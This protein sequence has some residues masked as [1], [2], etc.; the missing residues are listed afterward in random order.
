M[1]KNK[2]VAFLLVAAIACCAFSAIACNNEKVTVPPAVA[3]KD[4][5]VSSLK[6]APDS[7]D[8]ETVIYAVV[9]KIKSYSTYTTRSTGSSVAKKGFITY[10]QNTECT[11]VKNGDE[12]YTD[13][14]SN[15][16]LVNT[17]HEV[18]VKNGKAA[19][20]NNSGTI[21]TATYDD[22]LDIYGVTPDKTISG[23]VFNHD[24][25]RYA[26]LEK[27]EGDTYT[28]KIVLDKDLAHA[29]I[30]KQMKMV[31]GLD[32]YPVFTKDTEAT[33][34]IKKDFTPVS[35]SYHSSYNI[36]IA[37]LGDV[38][39]T[40]EN[41]VYFENINKEVTLPDANAFN[42]A[43][44]EQPT[45]VDPGKTESKDENLDA[46]VSALLQADLE[47]GI[48]L[49]GTISVGEFS[50][51]VKIEGKADINGLMNGTADLYTA[52]QATASIVSPAGNAEVT[53]YNGKFYLN[54]LGGKYVFSTNI[55]A[56]NRIGIT[57][58]DVSQFIKITKSEDDESTYVVTLADAYNGLITTAL[59]SAGLIENDDEF[60]LSFNAYVRGGRAGVIGADLNIGEIALDVEF[61]FSDKKYNLPADLDQYVSEL[62]FE[63]S[64]EV[65]LGGSFESDEPGAIVT[66]GAQYDMTQPNPVKAFKAEI[67]L[68]IAS[69]IKTLLGMASSFSS[70]LPDWFGAFSEAD[71]VNIVVE[72]GCAYF[73]IRKDE[74]ITYFQK[75]GELGSTTMLNEEG[76]VSVDFDT[77]VS[78]LPIIK[79]IL[80]QI[81]EGQY[82]QGVLTVG[83]GSDMVEL[84]NQLF[85]NNLQD[86]LIDVMGRT[87]GVMV[88]MMLNLNSPLAAIEL[89]IPVTEYAEIK[90]TLAVYVYDLG[91]TE[92][93]DENKEYDQV[94]LVSLVLGD[95]ETYS[96]TWDMKPL[97]ENYEN[98]A[99]VRALMSE[100]TENYA[101][102]EQYYASI[103]QATAAYEALTEGQKAMVFNAYY[104]QRSLFGGATYTFLPEKV[105][106]DYEK[107]K[108][109][110]DD[111]ASSV[112]SAKIDTLNYKYNGFTPVQLEYLA[113]NYKE[114]L[115]SYFEKRIESESDTKNAIIAAIA[116]IAQF[117]VE[118]AT[119]DQLYNRVIELEKV[120]ALIV[121][122][123]P[124]TLEDV[125]LTD[126]NSQLDL[127]VSAYVEKLEQTANAYVEEMKSMA[128]DCTL[129]PQQLIEK[130]S[131][132]A[133][134]A[135]KYCNSL[136]SKS[137]GALITAKSPKI[138]D[139]CYKVTLYN[140]YNR[141]GMVAAAAQVAEKAID[142]LI[143]GE[144]DEATINAKVAE[145]KTIV[146]YTDKANVS[147][148]DKFAEYIA[149]SEEKARLA[150]I[151]AK[152]NDFISEIDEIMEA[153][154]QSQ[155]EDW[156]DFDTESD[157]AYFIE[158][159]SDADKETFASKIEELNRKV[160]ELKAKYEA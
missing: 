40:E 116:E 134:F 27:A 141:K 33:L 103:A 157:I 13:S 10:T 109:A 55:P 82:E 18:M 71:N 139:A 5:E 49:N 89:N 105:K 143:G 160:N 4:T 101:L 159:L 39:C 121:K 81:I 83:L 75:L 50:L 16:T 149:E 110:V 125:D 111:F 99:A 24:S 1:K 38:G 124:D 138:E 21:D 66:V 95:G 131:V 112:E 92:V 48:A 151:E 140:Q 137:V 29:L 98:S 80:P 60:A 67:N 79:E 59:K 64:L 53:Y 87:G 115:S 128:Y 7:Y 155:Y 15:S 156:A 14:V 20:R 47:N 35:Y 107:D 85:W 44:N 119:L 154:D 90:P 102:T 106:A 73:V 65:Y 122:C 19:Y 148:Y 152:F 120:Y 3:G 127:A 32:G 6:N 113:S 62:S 17:R 136:V 93:Y 153:D 77:I 28:Y 97:A 144:Y 74:E 43:I 42:G 118:G 158:K 12:Y 150:K 78:I 129:T 84:V 54:L 69:N 2:I 56:E 34:V 88:P 52:F 26:V 108:K 126:F 9:G 142:D 147:N 96:Y 31:G 70:E 41:I 146:G 135:E 25:I 145:I 86:M 130:H 117:D 57:D 68:E 51:P 11:K 36:S 123:L 133:A 22:Y 76:G 72:D 23:H 63:K 104:V 61:A 114:Q 8:A 45:K 37:V 100:L 46:L 94:S 30:V 58:I 91:A 132:Y